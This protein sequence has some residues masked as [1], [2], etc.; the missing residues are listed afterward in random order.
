MSKMTFKIQSGVPRDDIIMYLE[1]IALKRIGDR[2]YHGVDWEIEVG[3]EQVRTLGSIKLPQT[4]V[5]F[6]VEEK[7]LEKIVAAFRLKFLSAGG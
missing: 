4:E 6:C 3:E 5:C 7:R 2:V 1:S